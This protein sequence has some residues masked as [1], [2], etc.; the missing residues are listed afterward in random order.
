ML[1]ITIEIIMP[2][3]VDSLKIQSQRYLSLNQHKIRHWLASFNQSNAIN[4]SLETLELLL[5]TYRTLPW[6]KRY[7]QRLTLPITCIETFYYAQQF[8]QIDKKSSLEAKLLI[9]QAHNYLSW[10][11]PLRALV[12]KANIF[13]QQTSEP[14]IKQTT[15]MSSLTTLIL[16]TTQ[17][18]TSTVV[19]TSKNKLSRKDPSANINNVSAEQ[20]LNLDERALKACEKLGLDRHQAI[21]WSMIRQAYKKSAKLFHPD[22]NPNNPAESSAQFKIHK[23]AYEWLD[24]FME[25]PEAPT[26][27]SLVD[28]SRYLEKLSARVETLKVYRQQAAENLKIQ[29]SKI[30]EFEEHFQKQCGK[31]HQHTHQKLH[32]LNSYLDLL[33]KQHSKQENCDQRNHKW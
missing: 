33:L 30:L 7:W 2:T 13:Y 16:A 25:N 18:P 6:Y 12:I 29:S 28:L 31:F 15:A 32:A 17:V 22:K 3:P 8:I 19:L 24:K 23:E 26:T 10:F 4:P 14:T 21:T 5:N 1:L 27:E 20:V 11:S 9:N